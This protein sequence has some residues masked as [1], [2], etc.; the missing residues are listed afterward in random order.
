VALTGN[1]DTRPTNQADM[2][3]QQRWDTMRGDIAR[4]DPLQDPNVV[5]VRDPATGAIV[6]HTKVIGADGVARAGTPIDPATGKPAAT[7][8]DG[9]TTPQPGPKV[10]VGRFEISEGELAAM[11]ERQA[12]D[13]LRKATLPATPDAYKA[14]LPADLKLPGGLKYEFRADDPNL[15]AARNW[16]H[17]KG[18]DQGAFSE[19][20]GIYAGHEAQRQHEMATAQAQEVSKLGPNAP[21][22]VDAIARFLKAEVG[23][24]DAAIILRTTVSEP[25]VRFF[26]HIMT[27]LANQRSGSFSSGRREADT[28]AKLTQ[29]QYDKLSYSQKKEY[30]ERSGGR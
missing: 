5:L 1:P 16:A 18:L 10:Q 17:A 12:N 24:K 2:N 27:R 30:A 4:S 6:P 9:T 22:R 29:E 21:A 8:A 13:D 26:E 23:D 3:P 28:G 7:S 20:L 11:M 15:A 25:Q 19:L 14:E